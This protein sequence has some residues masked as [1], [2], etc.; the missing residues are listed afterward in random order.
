MKVFTNHTDTVVAADLADVAEVLAAH[1]GSTMEQVRRHARAGRDINQR[2][3]YHD[4]RLGVHH[5]TPRRSDSLTRGSL[6]RRRH[7]SEW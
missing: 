1:Y 6:R 5:S 4:H 7:R 2:A 3:S